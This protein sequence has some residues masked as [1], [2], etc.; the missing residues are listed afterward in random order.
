MEV[1]LGKVHFSR[2]VFLEILPELVH[3]AILC[4]SERIFRIY[5]ICRNF[6]VPGIIILNNV[7]LGEIILILILWI[8]V[9]TTVAFKT[10]DLRKSLQQEV[11]K[12][13]T[14]D[15]NVFF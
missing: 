6:S 5:G 15:W 14:L 12:N 3:L 7:I 11:L 9:A 1:E 13:I 10:I 4:L 2:E 8:L